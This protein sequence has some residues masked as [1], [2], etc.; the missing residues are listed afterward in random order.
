MNALLRSPKIISSMGNSVPPEQ[1]SI[2]SSSPQP[3]LTRQKEE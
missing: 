2:A 1:T 3:A